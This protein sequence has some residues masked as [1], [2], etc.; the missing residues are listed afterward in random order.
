MSANIGHWGNPI[1][2]PSTRLNLLKEKKWFF[3]G[4]IQLIKYFL[5][6]LLTKV[7]GFRKSFCK[8]L[9]KFY[10]QVDGVAVGSPLGPILAN[11]FPS[12]DE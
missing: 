5:D 9:N 7:L 4:Q 6:I 10:I 11:I 12:H 3:G 8:L 1:A 2:T